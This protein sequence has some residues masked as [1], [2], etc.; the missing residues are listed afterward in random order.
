[1]RA[2]TGP[3]PFLP[4][5]PP[6]QLD[7]VHAIRDAQRRGRGHADRRL[8][9]W[10][11][12]TAWRRVVHAME[13]A[14]IP[15]GPH[16]AP[17]G[18]R[19][20]FGV[21]AISSNVPLNML[22]KW[23]GHASMETTAIYANALRAEEHGI[24]AKVWDTSQQAPLHACSIRLQTERTDPFRGSLANSYHGRRSSDSL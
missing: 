8:W 21:H 12:A 24:A 14:G 15:D 16:R 13:A 5:P 19:H 3:F 17:K 9:A 2:S 4:A 23:M 20:G 6:S 11:P 1:M 18:L 7:L 10:S 22:C